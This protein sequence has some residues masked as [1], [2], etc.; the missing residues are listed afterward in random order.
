MNKFLKIFLKIQIPRCVIISIY[1]E[2]EASG[3]NKWKFDENIFDNTDFQMCEQNEGS[4]K[5]NW[6]LDGTMCDSQMCE[7]LYK[8]KVQYFQ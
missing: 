5:N 2:N 8:M 4:G 1:K 7:N 3:Q 6:Q